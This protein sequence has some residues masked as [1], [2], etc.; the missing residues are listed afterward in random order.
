M[1]RCDRRRIPLNLAS[2]LIGQ[3]L[4]QYRLTKELGKG[5]FATVYRAFQPTLNRNVAIK[6]LHPEFLRD[7]RALRRFK[8]EALAV[9]RLHH[10]NIVAVYD[11]GEH[12][13]RAYLVMEYVAG[14]TLK[15]RLGKPVPHQLALDVMTAVGSALDY[16][17]GKGLIHRDIKPGNILFTEDNRIVLSDFGIVRLAD[18]DDSS[19]TRGIIGTPY[20]MSPEQAMGRQVDGRSDL[21]SL[22]VLLFEML[23][24]RVPYKGDSPLATLSMHATLPVPSARE[25]NARLTEEIDL[26]VQRGMAKAPEERYQTGAELREAL[27]TAIADAERPVEATI[28]LSPTDSSPIP[29]TG[30]GAG[31]SE[32]AS[33]S[34]R[35]PTP[36]PVQDLD[37]MYQLL[38]GY[39]RRGDWRA[40]VAL[41]G[42]I[43]GQEPNYRDV[44]AILASASNELR[45]G[46]SEAS[47]DVQVKGLLAQAETSVNGGHLMQAASLLQQVLR[48][49]PNHERARTLL[50]EVNKKLAEQ[51][52]GRQRERRLERLYTLAQSK[53]RAGDW[54]WANNILQ[55]IETV[56]P[57]YRDV[58]DLL[59]QAR[60]ALEE[61]QLEV[62]SPGDVAASRDQAEAA[63]REERWADAVALWED[64]LRVEPNLAGVSE[65]LELARHHALLVDLNAQAAR[66]AAEGKWEEA[67]QKLEEAKG[68]MA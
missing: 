56:D 32:T 25:A 40:A 59:A 7:Q 20:Y 3:T 52:A 43:L 67:M 45:F 1:R 60:A 5:G 37:G 30:D 2:D 21:Y 44:N 10:P 12:D 13:G 6:I 66:L 38:L 34:T 65:R 4:G 19:L 55:E 53:A 33:R 28:L 18:E 8:R 39:T 35:M 51:E 9:A 62:A 58:P 27:A 48:L 24:G 31:A 46:R 15:A 36:T 23:T 64:I 57:E 11:Y 54:R 63:M 49:S 22:G 61:S 41:A 68:L 42:Q 17:H 16:A 29:S 47:V 14:N 50:N 26:V